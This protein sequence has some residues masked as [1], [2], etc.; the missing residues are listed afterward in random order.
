MRHRNPDT[1]RPKN[2]PDLLILDGLNFVFKVAYAQKYAE[3]EAN[4]ISG[5][6]GMIKALIGEFWPKGIIL[7]WD[8]PGGK[9]RRLQLYPEYKGN[10]DKSDLDT[11]TIYEQVELL[12][13]FLYYLGIGTLKVNEYEADDLIASLARTCEKNQVRTLVVSSDQDFYQ[14]VSPYVSV[15][16]SSAKYGQRTFINYETFEGKIGISP[17]K[18]LNFTGLVGDKSDNIKGIEGIGDVTAKKLLKQHTIKEILEDSS[19]HTGYAK[20]LA[21]N[22]AKDIIFRNYLL[23]SLEARV[24]GVVDKEVLEEI[25][26]GKLNIE[27]FNLLCEDYFIEIPL[28]YT[29]GFDTMNLKEIVNKMKENNE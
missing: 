3:M 1:F 7:V 11:K 26:V 21:K 5:T 6:L 10:R 18:Y 13:E 8:G 9:A 29:M 16:S 23:M 25:E 27:E 15:C 2:C 20:N 24:T 14:F 19:L 4:V 28:Q 22:D 12:D 17:E